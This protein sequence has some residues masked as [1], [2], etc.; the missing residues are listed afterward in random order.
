MNL[1]D[2]I[3]AAGASRKRRRIGR[4][5]GSGN[6]KTSGRGHK[7]YGSRSGAK[8]RLGYEGG[9]TPVLSR[10]PK[11]G[12]NNIRFRRSYQIVNLADLCEAYE[13]GASVDRNSLAERGL[14]DPAGPG[15]KVLGDGEM[16]CK[17]TIQADRFS[18]SAKEKIA[19]AGGEVREL[20][21]ATSSP[22]DAPAKQEASTSEDASGKASNDGSE[23]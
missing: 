17:L 22:A 5:I 15:V 8:K 1:D 20:V 9:Q 10:I 3:S 2:I 23:E 18:A 11:R 13:D 6:G 19:Q 16:S 14:I 12:F 21:P 4:G 7:G